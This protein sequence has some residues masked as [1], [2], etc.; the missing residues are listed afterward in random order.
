MTGPAQETDLRIGHR[1]LIFSETQT[2]DV[3]SV[4]VLNTEGQPQGEAP[5]GNEGNKDPTHAQNRICR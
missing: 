3:F 5:Q 1:N 2:Q 4:Q